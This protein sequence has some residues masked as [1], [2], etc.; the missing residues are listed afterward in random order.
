MLD[1]SINGALLALRKQ[2][3]RGKQD[4]LEHVEALLTMRGVH[5]RAVL[6]A[7][8]ACAAGR[9]HSRAWI[10][11]ALRDGPKRRRDI[12]RHVASQRDDIPHEIAYRRVDQCLW[13]MRKT[14]LVR[15][16][17]GVWKLVP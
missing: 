4:G 1:K 11:D 3:I 12:V 5:M 7:K 16:E 10:L 9:G 17:D 15:R 14:G 13:K 2:I 8:R 6:P